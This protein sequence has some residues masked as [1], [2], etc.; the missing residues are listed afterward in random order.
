MWEIHYKD[1]LLR[2]RA[3]AYI[4]GGE[5]KIIRQH[6]KGKLTARERL[7]ILLD[8]ES[9]V[10]I[11]TLIQSHERDTCLPTEHIPGDGVVTGYGAVNGKC[12]CVAAEDFT[13][14]GGTLG[15]YHSRKIIAIMDL[16]M[17]MRVP[18]VMLNDSGGARIEEGVCSLNGYSG[19]FMRNTKASGVIPQI[20][21][22]MGPCAGG[23]CYSP[24]I[25]D[26]VFMVD[27]TSYMFITG[28]KVISAT[29]GETIGE[30][31]LGGS[32]IHSEI[33]GVAHF[34][35]PDDKSCLMGVRKLLDYLPMNNQT[36]IPFQK[37]FCAPRNLLEELV[38]DNKRRPYDIHDVIQSLADDSSVM[39]VQRD[40]ARNIVV[41]FARIAGRTCGII[42]NQ[43]ENLAGSLDIDASDK[44]ARFVRFCDCFG[45]PLVVLVDVPGFWPSKNQEYGGIIRH[46]AKLLYAFSEAS[47]PKITVILRKAYG[48][49]Y[50]AMNSKGMGADIVFAWPIA[51]LAVMGEE[52]AVNIIY[53]K[54]IEQSSEPEKECERLV[55]EY[56]NKF[57]SPYISTSNGYIDEIILPEETRERIS[58]ALTA[59]EN[60]QRNRSD[61]SHG[62]IPL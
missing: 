54:Q 16:A 60:K 51:E 62:N 36:P 26:F 13:V 49:A 15:E 11:N 29:T 57:V 22:I 40:F 48:G 12:I 19:I 42:A 18:F 20:A 33:S 7:K 5:K 2:K 44:A 23:A 8:E 25:C 30:N 38:S 61:K 52:A 1:E 50:I 45:I 3:E 27:R 17:K 58:S 14:H 53:R 10:E 59:L 55:E 6:E 37:S 21:V 28:P 46:G 32:D 47:V 39:E 41:A 24:A 4:G 56:R 35:Y 34:H 43:P 31:D 9:F